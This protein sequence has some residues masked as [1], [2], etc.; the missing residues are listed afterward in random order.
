M[1]R[2]LISG[3]RS[4]P[5]KAQGWVGWVR[6]K[7]GVTALEY[8]LI[9]ALIAVVIVVG[10]AKFSKNENKVF[11]TVAKDFALKKLGLK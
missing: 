8:A 11:T 5:P 9:A 2:Y 10:V 1:L 4:S 3:Q 6:D 7:Q